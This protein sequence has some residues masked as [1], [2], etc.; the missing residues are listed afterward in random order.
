[1]EA[2]IPVNVT[3]SPLPAIGALLEGIGHFA[4]L[5][6]D[7]DGQER[8]LFLPADLAEYTGPWGKYGQKLAGCDSANDGR[9]NTEALIAAET[10]LGKWVAEVRAKYQ[11]EGR[12]GDVYIPARRE[13]ALLEVNLPH[14]FD[15]TWYWSSTQYSAYLAWVQYFEDGHATIDSKG[16]ED[17]GR[18]VRSVLLHDFIPSSTSAVAPDKAAA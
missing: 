3:I 12:V 13:L 9:A 10:P 18:L 5:I 2:T 7:P 8:L 11:A 17:R 16:T 6:R 14:L 4:G 1:M 15:K